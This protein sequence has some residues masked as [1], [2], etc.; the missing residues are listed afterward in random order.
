MNTQ[1]NHMIKLL[2]TSLIVVC[3]VLV[4]VL[5]VEV[6]RDYSIIS[7]TANA[8][9]VNQPLTTPAIQTNDSFVAIEAYEDIINRPL[10]NDDRKPYVY[11]EPVVQEKPPVKTRGRPTPHKPQQQLSL[12]AIV[13]TPEKSLAILQA[14]KDKSLQRVRLGETIDGWT[15]DE[16]QDQSIVL[17]QGERTQTLELEVKGSDKTQKPSLAQKSDETPPQDI[18]TVNEDKK[19]DI[20]TENNTAIE[21]GQDSKQ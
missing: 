15:L 1:N 5:L 9:S 6:N 11:T 19:P 21:K 14:G 3:V 8:N 10:F 20:T 2:Q 16:I 4:I 13:I 18:V 12:T 7:D 17:K